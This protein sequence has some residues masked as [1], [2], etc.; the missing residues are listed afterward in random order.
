MIQDLF[1]SNPLAWIIGI[2]L[3]LTIIAL[4]VKY[5]FWYM[6]V[7]MGV[8]LFIAVLLYAA[9][10]PYMEFSLFQNLAYAE[11]V[12]QITPSIWDD[13]AFEI[14]LAAQIIA[15]LL[16]A[17]ALKLSVKGKKRADVSD[18]QRKGN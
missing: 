11:R 12:W 3:L 4:A 2:L 15:A 7:K 16:V 1:N 13:W 5:R 17:Y 18:C 9:I 10:I 6:V 14:H 8:A